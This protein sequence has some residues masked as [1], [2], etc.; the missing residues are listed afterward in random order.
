[1]ACECLLLAE[2]WIT[3][4]GGGVTDARLDQERR[5]SLVDLRMLEEFMLCGPCC[6]EPPSAPTPDANVVEHSGAGEYLIVAAGVLTIGAT[7]IVNSS[8]NNLRLVL[9]DPHPVPNTKLLTFDTHDLT[10]MANAVHIVKGTSL[11]TNPAIF[12]VNGFESG[13]FRIQYPNGYT[14]QFMIEVSMFLPP[15]A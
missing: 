1:M 14:G 15:G 5:P 4:S 11:G 9:P 2:V 13:A 12:H 8:Y 7:P 10:Q 3:R 6:G